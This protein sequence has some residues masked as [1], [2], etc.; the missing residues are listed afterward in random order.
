MKSLLTHWFLPHY[1]NNHRPKLLQPIGLAVVIAVFLLTQSSL[2]LFLL[3]PR[4]P[5][6]FVLGYASSISPEQVVELTNME[7][8]KLGLP[9]LSG[10]A[11]LS[12]AALAKANHMFANDYWAHVAPDGT[13]PWSF[14]KAA[15]YAYSVAGENLARDFNDT[16]SMVQ[17]WMNSETHKTN[18]VHQKYSQIGVAV[19]NGKLQGVETTLVVQLFGVPTGAVA[20]TTTEAAISTAPIPVPDPEPV[21]L[22]VAALEPA[23]EPM[24]VEEPV[25]TTNQTPLPVINEVTLDTRQPGIEASKYISPLTITKV[26]GTGLI[27]LLVL[28]LT[29]DSI[30]ISKKK[31]PRQVGN[32]WAHI[33]FFGIILLI[34]VVMTQGKVI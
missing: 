27:V 6:G 18:I 9:P 29:Y 28:V 5:G 4:L 10:N 8:S 33:G 20:R 26:I 23:A 3:A 16:P 1:T 15:G 25:T 22:E 32:N 11:Q 17:A 30:M 34:I 14:I 12:Q 31:L 2:R 21:V 24:A 19:V 7:R 13:T